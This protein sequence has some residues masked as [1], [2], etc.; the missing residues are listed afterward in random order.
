MS[1]GAGR[2]TKPY[3]E[4]TGDSN[5]KQTSTQSAGTRLG[6]ELQGVYSD[7]KDVNATKDGGGGG[8]DN[9]EPDATVE[10]EEPGVWGPDGLL[11]LP[12]VKMVLFLAFVVQVCISGARGSK[13]LFQYTEY[14]TTFG[15]T[16]PDSSR[17]FFGC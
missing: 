6:L 4:L 10:N 1:K 14:R 17:G 15:P 9:E 7:D 5:E 11:A 8:G 12:H 13:P 3:Q 16:F 2:G